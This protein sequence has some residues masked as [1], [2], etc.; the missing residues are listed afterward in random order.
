VAGQFVAGI[1]SAVE[2]SDSS[3]FL[4]RCRNLERQVW[5][6]LE[7]GY[8]DAARR[9]EQQ[10]ALPAQTPTVVYTS[11]VARFENFVRFGAEPPLKW[12]GQP[13]V[14]CYQ[15]PNLG[16]E[17]YVVESGGQLESHWFV[18]E[19]LF[20]AGKPARMFADYG[21]LLHALATGEAAWRT[22]LGACAA[23][24]APLS[25]EVGA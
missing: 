1:V 18:N 22:G 19:A 11:T 14:S 8:V 21:G 4:E 9:W 10:R 15:M 2:V 13:I 24:T 5:T 3:T 20:T 12:F 6:D 16:L 17:F 25:V 23:G 7:H